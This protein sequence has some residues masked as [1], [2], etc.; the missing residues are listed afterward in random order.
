MVDNNY[1]TGSIIESYLNDIGVIS[2]I[3]IE[4]VRELFN[5]GIKLC[6]E[7]LLTIFIANYDQKSDGKVIFKGLWLFSDNYVLETLNFL[8]S[9]SPKTE[10]TR[11]NK[12]IR[13]VTVDSNN[14][15]FSEKPSDASILHIALYTFHSFECDFI[16]YGQNCNNLYR[17][18]EDYIKDNLATVQHNEHP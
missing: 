11:F 1:L 18:Y 16:A 7:K 6:P 9:P 8:N 4:R 17:I 14:Y 12:N 15:I 10:I 3:D 5:L 2:S 13:Y